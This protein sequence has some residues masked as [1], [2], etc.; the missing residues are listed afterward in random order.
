[1]SANEQDIEQLEAYLDGELS[2]QESAVISERVLCNQTLASSLDEL[3]ADRIVRR[4]IFAAGEPCEMATAALNDRIFAATD[5]LEAAVGQ[6]RRMRWMGAAAACLVAG[7]MGG[8][9]LHGDG[10]T[11]A[12]QSQADIPAVAIARPVVETTV[13]RDARRRSSE[14]VNYSIRPNYDA[15]GRYVSDK[16]VSDEQGFHDFLNSGGANVADRPHA[17]PIRLVGDEKN[18]K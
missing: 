2:P 17:P 10:A 5:R 6:S 12:T 7:F 4:A 13:P 15:N 8:Y 14:L 16:L 18:E 1:M 3:R 11:P 9:V